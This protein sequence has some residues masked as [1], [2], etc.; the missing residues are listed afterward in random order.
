[1]A[2]MAGF[3][4]IFELSPEALVE[5]VR[6]LM[7]LNGVSYDPPAEIPETPIPLLGGRIH[8]VITNVNINLRQH[9]GV[10]ITFTF[11]RG[12][13]FGRPGRRDFTNLTGVITINSRFSLDTIRTEPTRR[14]LTL[15]LNTATVTALVRGA[16][17]LDGILA[18]GFMQLLSNI[19]SNPGFT[20]PLEVDPTARHNISP[21]VFQDL[22]LSS[23]AVAG[24]RQALVLFAN[25]LPGFIARGDTEQFTE[26]SL[27]P[28]DDVSILISP[29]LFH[30]LVFRP[31]VQS[32]LGLANPDLL[33]ATCGR[34]E[35]APLPA[36]PE[37]SITRISDSFRDGRI[38]IEIHARQRAGGEGDPSGYTDEFQILASLLLSVRAN[39]L[40]PQIRRDEVHGS[41]T[42]GF[43]FWL[44]GIL[45][46]PVFLLMGFR[47]FMASL[48]A[49]ELT[50]PLRPSAISI[51]DFI[52]FQLRN[53]EISTE[54]LRLSGTVN[55]A[56]RRSATPTLQLDTIFV[57]ESSEAVANGIYE[58][59]SCPV[60]Y[61]RWVRWRHQQFMKITPSTSLASFPVRYLWQ[62]RTVGGGPAQTLDGSVIELYAECF[63]PDTI[64]S[65]RVIQPVRLSY[66]ITSE[67]VIKIQNRPDDAMF[68]LSLI[69]TA[70]DASGARMEQV[71]HFDFVGLQTVLGANADE[72]IEGNWEDDFAICTQRIMR[73]AAEMRGMRMMGGRMSDQMPIPHW[74]LAHRPPPWK[75]S[76]F[77]IIASLMKDS[78]ESQLMV[79]HAI[80]L[81]G[82]SIVT[83][84]DIDPGLLA[85]LF[86]S[87]KK[88]QNTQLDPVK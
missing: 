62:I 53:A 25:L 19:T 3:D 28:G 23:V 37:V 34:A 52:P 50:L 72:L 44:L 58:S 29:E 43:T 77:M 45:S 85:S 17:E 83:C 64:P 5:L 49:N 87:E 41:T 75:T 74:I 16:R 15:Q 20:L 70:I 59:T 82:P 4:M 2:N 66:N 26:S 12:S 78:K 21:P 31:L 69:C 51:P 57:T 79:D 81:Y 68:H 10:A 42:F 38:E 22:R 1:M 60:G 27:A 84:A 80:T 63:I 67:G 8:F 47:S 32:V 86:L 24:R 11:E 30:Q 46:A 54:H 7:V 76:D 39:Q 36:R 40:I 61:Y 71:F 55:R 18:G 35:L 6:P 13:A 48:F 14:R 88:L 56:P 73:A 65:R 9:A 33:P